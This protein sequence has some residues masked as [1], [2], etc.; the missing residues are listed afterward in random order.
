[1]QNLAF[2]S[3]ALAAA[4]ASLPALA[5]PK[6]KHATEQLEAY[7]FPDEELANV[8]GL[9]EGMTIGSGH[10]PVRTILARPRTHF[11]PELLKGVEGL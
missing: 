1:M 4:L 10:Q 5:E 8:K 3:F 2:V 11:I 7:E 6:T 9:T